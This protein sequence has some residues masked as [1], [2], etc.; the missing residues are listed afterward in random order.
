M[1]ERRK[2]SAKELAESEERRLAAQECR[3]LAERQSTKEF[4]EI[5][6]RKLQTALQASEAEECRLAA[7]E[8]RLTPDTLNV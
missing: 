2:Q 5:E 6:E 8:R 3:I 7:E 1:E 4:V